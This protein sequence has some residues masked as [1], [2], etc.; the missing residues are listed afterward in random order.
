VSP[1]PANGDAS[2][3]TPG[4]MVAGIDGC[5]G[6]WVVVT[7]EA[8][9]GASRSINRV[10]DLS[11]IVAD[12]DSGRLG[13]VAIDIPIGLPDE[14]SRRCDLEARKLI[15]PRRSSVS[16]HRSGASSGP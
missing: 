15:G 12:L 5:A 8:D 4:V 1:E 16:R 13:A 10:D 9:G 2:R 7:V 11:G 14:G 6:G 3:M